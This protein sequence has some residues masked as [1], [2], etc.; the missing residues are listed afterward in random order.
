MFSDE[1]VDLMRKKNVANGKLLRSIN[2]ALIYIEE[3]KK[4]VQN[5][6]QILPK[7]SSVQKFE[8]SQ[9]TSEHKSDRKVSDE[10]KPKQWE[11]EMD[12]DEKIRKL[13]ESFEAMGST[14]TIDRNM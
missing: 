9:T 4:K 7:V 12:E 6:I 3:R 11:E 8:D 13:R 10:M 2:E 14:V 1:L 5:H